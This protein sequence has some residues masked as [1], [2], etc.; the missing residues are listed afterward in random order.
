[1][2]QSA[3]VTS[4][5]NDVTEPWPKHGNFKITKDKKTTIKKL[6]KSRLNSTNK[7]V[8]NLNKVNI[9]KSSKSDPKLNKYASNKVNAVSR[10]N[11]KSPNT[12]GMKSAEK[13]KETSV[14]GNRLMNKNISSKKRTNS[15]KAKLTNQNRNITKNI[16]P[17]LNTE[18]T[19]TTD[20]QLLKKYASLEKDPSKKIYP[21]STVHESTVQSKK[22]NHKIKETFDKNSQ[23]ISHPHKNIS[24]NN[25]NNTLPYID[26]VSML[27]NKSNTHE[28]TNKNSMQIERPTL[29]EEQTEA[30]LPNNTPYAI[31]EENGTYNIKNTSKASGKSIFNNIIQEF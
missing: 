8:L 18:S 20:S 27:E 29:Q 30:I 16:I 28:N 13:T 5:L 9:E 11:R 12:I 7:K 4:V 15:P 14:L 1:M 26:T 19:K 2:P 3:V 10:I 24:K 25:V 23:Q 22:P 31:I 17:D 6:S 21:E